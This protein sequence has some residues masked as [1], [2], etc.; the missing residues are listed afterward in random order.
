MRHAYQVRNGLYQLLTNCIP[1]AVV[2]RVLTKE[3]LKQCMPAA[4][5]QIV[6]FEPRLRQ[7]ASPCLCRLIVGCG[8]VCACADSRRNIFRHPLA[9]R[10]QRNFPSGSIRGESYVVG[11]KLS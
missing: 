7:L 1:G 8:G 10:V 2:L 11:Q 5:P 9:V 6:R 4:R 3:L